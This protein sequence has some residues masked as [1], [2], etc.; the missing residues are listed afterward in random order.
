M[1]I[2]YGDKTY[3]VEIIC[4]PLNAKPEDW[5]TKYAAGVPRLSFTVEELKQYGFKRSLPSV[6]ERLSR[7]TLEDLYTAADE[8]LSERYKVDKF[9]TIRISATL[10]D[11]GSTLEPGATNGQ[12]R[13]WCPVFTGDLLTRWDLSFIPPEDK[14]MIN[15]T[16]RMNI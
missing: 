3:A 5:N 12:Y 15:T 14:E 9:K 4:F 16:W 11:C 7:E 10:R 13:G 2:Y 8:A 1:G 6:I